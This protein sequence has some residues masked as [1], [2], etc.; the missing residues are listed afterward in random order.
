MIVVGFYRIAAKIHHDHG[1]PGDRARL[2]HHDVAQRDRVRQVGY[3]KSRERG[4]RGGG[5]VAGLGGERGRA[6]DGGSAGQC[7]EGGRVAEGGPAGRCG[8]GHIS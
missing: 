2:A 8:V 3:G 4:D 7:G 6:A 1:K 5:G